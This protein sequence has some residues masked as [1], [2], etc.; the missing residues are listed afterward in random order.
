M[1]QIR[2]EV[3]I[4]PVERSGIA[5]LDEETRKNLEM[6]I[7]TH[8][9]PHFDFY[10]IKSEDMITLNGIIIKDDIFEDGLSKDKLMTSIRKMVRVK[11]CIYKVIE[12]LYTIP[13]LHDF[14]NSDLL[15][16]G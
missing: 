6:Q 10:L 1:I 12:S 14:K 4:N 15:M 13:E 16:F 2:T 7:I 11:L 8:L 9:Y 5:L 3:F